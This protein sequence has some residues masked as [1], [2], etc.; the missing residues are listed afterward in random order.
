VCTGL[1]AAYSIVIPSGEDPIMDA[2]RRL[3]RRRVLRGGGAGLAAALATDLTHA[4]AQE[5]TPAAEAATPVGSSP[6]LSDAAMGQFEAD[7]EAAMGKFRMVGAAVALVDR[8]GIRYHRGFGVRDLASGTPVTPDTHFFVASTTKSMSSLLVATVVD[9]GAFGWDQPV[10]E[11]WPDFRAPTDELTTTLRVR[12]LLGMDSGIG[13]PPPVSTFHEGDPT[14]DEL[15]RS[16][17]ALPVTD[18]PHTTYFYNNTVYAVGGYLPALVQGAS[19]E[20][21]QTVYARLMDERVYGPVGMRTARLTD[22]PRPFITD[23]ATGY[24]PDFTQET[25]AQPYPPVGAYA[26][27]GGTLASLTDMANYIAMQLNAGGSISGEHVVSAEN[28]AECWKPH[29]DLPPAPELDPDRVSAGYGMGWISQ[30]YRD[31]RRLVWHNGGID[32]FSTFIGFFPDDDLGLV[33]L[34]NMGPL[35][36]GLFF[37][38][39]VLNLVLSA[40]FGLNEGANAAVVAQYQAAEQHLSDLAA[41]ATPVAADAIAPYLGYY[42]KGW[43]LVFDADGTLRLR[44]SSRAIPLLALPDSDY[45]MASGELPGTAVRFSQDGSG[46]RWLEIQDIEIVRWSS[47]LA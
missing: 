8:S 9:D 25:A 21:L 7:I 33:V 23:Y 40:R 16:L 13:E 37:T 34:T 20:E 15:L 6:V 11:V 45:V 38:A 47:G 3:S 1:A 42:E 5:A 41:Q 43:R 12:D 18:P 30:T 22:D 46:M 4:A 31:G 24:A 27:I 10:H 35:P 44:Q 14:A 2:D 17:A 26:P 19:K 36:R 32:G 28:L 39:Y 29:I